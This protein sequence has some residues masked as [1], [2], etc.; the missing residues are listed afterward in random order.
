MQ[1]ST[2]IT[3]LLREACD[4]L[5]PERENITLVDGT[6]GRGGHSR[7]LLSRMSRTSRLIALDRD[8]AAEQTA[9]SIHDPRFCF[10]RSNFGAL[11]GALAAINVQRIDGLLLDIG[12][13]S[14][15]LDEGERGFSFMRDGPLDM[16]MD[17]SSGTS[18]ATWIAN[19]TVREIA[20]VIHDYGEERFA[21][22]IATAIVTARER[23]S[24]ERTVQLAQIVEKAVPTRGGKQHP[25]TK[26]FQAIRIHVNRELEELE[27]ALNVS[28]DVFNPGGRL[29]V[30]TFHSLE[31]R[32]VKL[33][34]RDQSGKTPEDP[35]LLRLP[36]STKAEPL[37]RTV[38]RDV[39]PSS[40]EVGAN[41]RARSARLR[42]AERTDAQHR[43]TR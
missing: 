29:A 38:G 18:A 20:D 3:V 5:S 40:S 34:M 36:Q 13:S 37:F 35:R 9:R 8:E 39:E 14:P 43:E 22:R 4:A 30:I 10:V 41:P 28:L 19:A 24:I 21:T 2:H 27:M 33:W 26:T 11:R 31:D 32:I 23:Q 16:R 6:F 1:S 7:M 25:A 15:Q 17:Q 12:V 42:I